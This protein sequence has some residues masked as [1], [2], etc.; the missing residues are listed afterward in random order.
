[1]M[2]VAWALV[3]CLMCVRSPSGIVPGQ[4]PDAARG[5][6]FWLAFDQSFDLPFNLQG[7]AIYNFILYI[8][9]LVTFTCG[10][11]YFYF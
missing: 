2:V 7:A 3:H 6:C 8:V 4:Y 5:K 9:D 10:I 1:M 11:E